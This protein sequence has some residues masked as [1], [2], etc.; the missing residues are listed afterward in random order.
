MSTTARSFFLL[1]C[2][3]QPQVFL[4][5]FLQLL[6][7]HL[8]G[9]LC[10]SSLLISF[11]LFHKG[12][13][14]FPVFKLHVL[15]THFFWASLR[16]ILEINLGKEANQTL[17]TGT[18]LSLLAHL[19]PVALSVWYI[20]IKWGYCCLEKSL[21]HYIWPVPEKWRFN[22]IMLLLIILTI[23]LLV[24]HFPITL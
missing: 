8:G 6:S 24:L 11:W 15:L 5:T 21:I 18:L 2:S 14:S 7:P 19:I 16:G 12:F 3:F 9:F 1:P 4:M 20:N 23:T 17:Q 22:F 10:S 13:P